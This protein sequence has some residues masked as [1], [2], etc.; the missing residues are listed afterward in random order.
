MIQ[1]PTIDD[2]R[3]VNIGDWKKNASSLCYRGKYT[4]GD[5]I[6]GHGFM[7]QYMYLIHNIPV[8][9]CTHNTTAVED[10]IMN[11]EYYGIIDDRTL[12]NM[13]NMVKNPKNGFVVLRTGNIITGIYKDNVDGL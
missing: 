3:R 13:R 9:I 5:F 4:V 10:T 2:Q 1:R 11:M 12:M 8:T 7:L 6:L